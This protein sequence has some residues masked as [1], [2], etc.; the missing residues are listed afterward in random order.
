MFVLYVCGVFVSRELYVG[1]F[2]FI[3]VIVSIFGGGGDGRAFFFVFFCVGFG[4]VF[5]VFGCW[6]VLLF[7]SFRW[8]W[9][10]MLLGLGVF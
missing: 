7:V 10:L 5:G 2:D 9:V 6:R 8:D 4:C 1:V 3:I